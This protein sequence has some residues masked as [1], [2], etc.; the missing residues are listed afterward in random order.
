MDVMRWIAVRARVTRT[1]KRLPPPAP[2]SAPKLRR[3]L[4]FESGA[5]VVQTV[6]SLAMFGFLLP[7]PLVDIQRLRLPVGAF[8]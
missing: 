1:F 4:P 7:L 2:E 3:N 5:N 6:P 8:R